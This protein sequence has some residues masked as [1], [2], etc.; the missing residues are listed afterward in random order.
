MV[1]RIEGGLKLA[2][3]VQP[4]LLEEIKA[5]QLQDQ[6]LNKVVDEQPEG[7]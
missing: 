3:I 4:N 6:F 2:I 5:N 1:P 7:R